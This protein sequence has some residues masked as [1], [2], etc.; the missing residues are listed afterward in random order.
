MKIASRII[1]IVIVFFPLRLSAQSGSDLPDPEEILSKAVKAITDIKSISYTAESYDMGVIK[2]GEKYAILTPHRG[3]VKLLRV[4]AMD[5]IGAKLI[6]S[7]KKVGT[8]QSFPFKVAYDCEKITKLDMSKKTC[9]INDPDETGKFLLVGA[10]E[11]ILE[12]FLKDKPY[13]NE[14]SAVESKY[15]GFAVIENI[16][17]HIVHFIFSQESIASESWWFFGADDYL[18]RKVRILYD[19]L[20]EQKHEHIL[21]LQNIKTNIKMDNKEFSIIVPEDYQI[22]EYLGFGVKKPTLSIGEPAPDWTLS[23]S[24]G[25]KYSL[26]DFK[27]KIIV[28]D[29]WA[30]WCGPCLKMMPELQKIHEKFLNQPAIV[31]GICTW[32]RGDPVTFMKEKGYGYKI[33]LNGDEVAKK[34]GVTGIP[35]LYVIG[36]DGKV[37]FG[38]VGFKKD[39]SEKIL[40][41]I[42]KELN[43]R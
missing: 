36:R 6:I 29:F 37:I 18:P 1:L 40:K 27:G 31:L 32:E 23:D 16:P 43:N 19:R 12:Y 30:T 5:P 2:Y 39:N 38:D 24:Q 34:Y 11:L 42:E 7:G 28:M 9:Y 41:T 21:I 15:G 33:L 20:P 22:K 4:D 3:D 35:T 14:Q 26:R 17:C 25:R 10:I 8:T 13:E